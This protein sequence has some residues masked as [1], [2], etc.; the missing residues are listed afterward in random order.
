MLTKIYAGL[1]MVCLV[2]AG[3]FYLTGNM[4]MLAVVGFGFVAFGMVFMGM[5][6]VLPAT[7]VHHRPA[8]AKVE[9]EKMPATERI[10]N[11]IRSYKESLSSNNVA[12]HKPRHP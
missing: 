4:T 6:G 8:L 2:T 1:W 9:V 10:G 12:V 7:V 11:R 5:M 3:V